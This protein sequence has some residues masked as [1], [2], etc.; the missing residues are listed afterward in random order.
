MPSGFKV[1]VLE[2]TELVGAEIV[3]VLDERGFPLSGLVLLGTRRSAG[4]RVEFQGRDVPVTLA[5]STS[6]RGV[7]LAF[8]SCDRAMSAEHTGAA[9]ASGATVIDLSGRHTL[10]D[11]VPF[12]V[13]EVNAEA[14]KQGHGI[15]ACPRGVT[16]QLGLSLAPIHR[17]ARITR[18]TATVFHAV[19]DH[20]ARAMDELTAQVRELFSFRE[21]SGQVFPQQIAFNCLPQVGPF[22]EGGYSEDELVIATETRRILGDPEIR[23]SVTCVQVPV[24]YSHGVS[25]VVETERKL[26]PERAREILG[27]A[28][29]VSLEDEPASGVYPTPVA[30]AGTDECLVGRIRQDLGAPNGIALWTACDNIRKGSALN[31]VQI[32][33]AL[34]RP[35]A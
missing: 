28:P 9:R 19:S 31:A 27:K 5:D 6:F 3:R 7:D 30:A 8:F 18:I 4:E 35:R 26:S 23:M 29:G 21:P 15:I 32:A 25:V 14:L 2:P 16:I 24:F 33:E 10:Q 22:T 1:A 34:F 11:D 12:V 13:P 20:G 17:D